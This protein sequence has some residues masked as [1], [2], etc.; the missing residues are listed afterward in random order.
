L[1]KA[2]VA[3]R[4][5]A[6]EKASEKHEATDSTFHRS[7]VTCFGERKGACDPRAAAAAAAAAVQWRLRAVTVAQNAP[8][9][10]SQARHKKA[11][12]QRTR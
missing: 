2:K 3:L 10:S 8:K 11:P 9:K 1:P 12:L 4:I 7:C 5:T 6:V